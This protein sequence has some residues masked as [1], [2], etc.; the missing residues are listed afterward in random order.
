[1]KKNH[2]KKIVSSLLLSTL[3]LS[4]ATPVIAAEDPSVG[5]PSKGTTEG[6]II[7]DDDSSEPNKPVKP[8]KPDEETDDKDKE[9]NPDNKPTGN[10][11]VLTLDVVPSEF[12][13]GI[14]NLSMKEA[15]YHATSKNKDED[16]NP[17]NYLQVTDKRT[18]SNGWTVVVSRTEF[19]SQEGN[20]L[21][22]STLTIPEGTPRNSLNEDASEKDDELITNEINLGV[23]EEGEGSH[24]IFRAPEKEKVGKDTSTN[25]WNV[26][27]VT[28]TV[29]ELTAKKGETFESTINWTL[30]AG[31]E[32]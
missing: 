2:Y 23:D 17:L 3:A 22:G 10:K 27:D 15:T 29:P 18:D 8:E 11:G 12:N 7:F 32:N 16:A 30:T 6:S 1:M 14:V 26:K 24:V 5:L 4:L 9:D 21:T 28:L 13:F 20:E 25:A 31:A 19:K